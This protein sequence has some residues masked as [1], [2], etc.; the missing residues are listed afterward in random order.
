MARRRRDPED[1]VQKLLKD[2]ATDSDLLLRFIKD[3]EGVMKEGKIPKE[4]RMFIR[5]CLALE[6][7]KRILI[8]PDTYHV[9]W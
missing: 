6:V 8:C 3:P 5:N 7:S 2:L 9:H 4:A 1:P